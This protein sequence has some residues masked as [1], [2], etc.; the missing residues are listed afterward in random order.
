MNDESVVNMASKCANNYYYTY[1]EK[2]VSNK[3]CIEDHNNNK[4]HQRLQENTH[5][6]KRFCIGN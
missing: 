1:F 2:C 5:L 3:K 6:L 4:P